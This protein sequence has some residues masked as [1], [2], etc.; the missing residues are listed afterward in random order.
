MS[1]SDE[2]S[3]AIE[4]AAKSPK[5]VQIGNQSAEMPSIDEQIKADQYLAAKRAAQRKTLGLRFVKL[6][7]PGAG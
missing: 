2:L 7:P 3:A 5:R 1:T 4:E 6:V